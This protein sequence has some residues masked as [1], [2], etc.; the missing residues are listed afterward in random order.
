MDGKTKKR[1]ELL[2]KRLGKLRQQLAGAVRQN[3]DP[4]E[5]ARLR[6]EVEEAEAEVRRLKEA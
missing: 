5:V 4:Q 2:Q 6:G 3:D 1:L